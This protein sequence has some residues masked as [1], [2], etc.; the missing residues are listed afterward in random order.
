MWVYRHLSHQVMRQAFLAAIYIL[1]RHSSFLGSTLL[2][3]LCLWHHWLKCHNL[4]CAWVNSIHS[5][6]LNLKWTAILL[7][8][9]TRLQIGKITVDFSKSITTAKNNSKWIRINN[10]QANIF[11]SRDNT[12]FLI[13]MLTNQPCVWS[14]NNL[15]KGVSLFL[16]LTKLKVGSQHML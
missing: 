9:C 1:R 2:G 10:V 12:L 14:T 11:E 6:K 8:L 3:F 16:F 13:A 15:N 5:D 4:M 7:N